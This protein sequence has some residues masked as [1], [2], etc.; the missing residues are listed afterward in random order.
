MRPDLRRECAGEGP[1]GLV[2]LSPKRWRR[3]ESCRAH[4]RE[5]QRF[6]S[7]TDTHA[8]LLALGDRVS[9][10]VMLHGPDSSNRWHSTPRVRQVT[11][12]THERARRVRR[13]S[14]PEQ[15]PSGDFVATEELIRRQGPR[16]F[17]SVDEDLA[18]RRFVVVDPRDPDV[19]HVP[20][21][22]PSVIPTRL[23]LRRR[24]RLLRGLGRR[25]QH[26]A[27][28]GGIGR[29]ECPGR[30]RLGVRGVELPYR[31]LDGG[32]GGGSRAQLPHA[33]PDQQPGGELVGGEFA[34]DRDGRAGACG[35]RD[36]GQQAGIERVGE[37]VAT[38]SLPRSAA[39]AYWVRSFVPMLKKSTCGANAARLERRRGH[40]DHDPD[41]HAGRDAGAFGADGVGEHV[42][43]RQQ[44]ADGRSPSGTSRRQGAPRRRGRSRA[45]GR[46][47]DPDAAARA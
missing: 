43:R 15:G 29:G 5:L 2:G 30:H 41:P 17:Q 27:D 6:R 42:A 25:R 38:A 28:A 46:A 39:S 35:S 23:R 18:G 1:D 45:A 22:A 31:L 14:A 26:C 11:A 3:F 4:Y 7:V 24:P 8:T 44:F 40:L 9:S 12:R 36:Q 19:A 13:C 47:A 33:Q 16:P 37:R 20:P 10:H 34:A 21:P 32:D